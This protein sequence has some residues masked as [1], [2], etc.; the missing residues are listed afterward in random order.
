MTAP[1]RVV[2]YG[3]NDSEAGFLA[4]EDA[5]RAAGARI[6]AASD[7][8]DSRYRVRTL[9]VEYTG[10]VADLRAVL[11]GAGDAA[12]GAP[13]R[14]VGTAVVP[15]AV[16]GPGRTLLVLDVDSTLIKQ[17]V[18]EL[19]AAFA[20]REAEVAAVTEAAMRGE[21]DFAQSL[22]ARVAVL[23]GLPEAVLDKVGAQIELS[24]GAEVMAEAFLGAGHLVAVVSGGFSQILDPLAARLRL[25]HAKA[26]VLEIRDGLL[27]GRVSGRVID[28]AEKERSLRRW[29][30]DAGIPLER[31][32]AV[33]DGANDLDML[34]AAGLGVAFNAKPAVRAAADASVDLP[35][36]DIVR[37]F[38]G[39]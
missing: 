16:F 25:T 19:L 24:E 11:P 12:A 28:R 15:G 23:A 3:L 4:V 5:V 14:P 38:A 27:T 22:H 26:N 17:E 13:V 7:G 29:A 1:F 9:T 35:Y 31:T 33:G 8:G 37:N 30:Q 34:G 2:S 21:I 32:I 10:P 20:G 36:L 39:I 6:L 18:I